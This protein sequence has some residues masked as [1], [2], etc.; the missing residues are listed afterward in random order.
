MTIEQIVEVAFGAFL[1]AGLTFTHTFVQ[2]RA[3][4]QEEHRARLT[5]LL[6]ELFDIQSAINAG[7]GMGVAKVALSDAMWKE[8]IGE[9]FGIPEDVREAVRKAYFKVAEFNSIILYELHQTSIG[10]GYFDRI[11]EVRRKEAT[12]LLTP[13]I[14]GLQRYLEA[15][16]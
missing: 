7:A 12:D 16:S 1:G 5:A 11:M 8:S 9:T 4:K 15:K 10:N 14:T 3:E 6:A 13:A 2:K